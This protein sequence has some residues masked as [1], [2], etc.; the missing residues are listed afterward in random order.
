MKTLS[1]LFLIILSTNSFAKDCSIVTSNFGKKD[2]TYLQYEFG[3]R[4]VHSDLNKQADFGIK[5]EVKDF[6]S[7]NINPFGNPIIIK[8]KK[9]SLYEDGNIIFE[10]K[11][12][13]PEKENPLIEVVSKLRTLGCVVR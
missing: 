13:N 11:Y 9:F 2:T 1:L 6:V 5:L 10:T 8:L 7:N 3:Y 12:S 4:E